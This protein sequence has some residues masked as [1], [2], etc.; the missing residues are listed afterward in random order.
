MCPY[1]RREIFVLDGELMMALSCAC[2]VPAH[3]YTWS[4]E[5]KL[6]WSG[7]YASSKE[8]FKYFD[9]FAR[10]YGLF[11]Y[12]KTSHQVTG[13]YWDDETKGYDITVN[14]LTTGN[15]IRTHCDIL[16]N[17]GGVLNNWR[18]PAIPGL[19]KYKGTL[20]HTANWDDSVS[21]DGK[22]VGLIGN[23]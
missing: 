8:I 21:L 13:A 2:D 17:A 1:P 18:W 22:H 20:L 3:N 10:K 6:D 4:F 16:I 7:V 9:D 5:P 19:D 14:D 11:D 12:V 15:E 23:G